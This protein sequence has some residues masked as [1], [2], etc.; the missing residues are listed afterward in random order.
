[1]PA[2]EQDRTPSSAEGRPFEIVYIEEQLEEGSKGPL[3]AIRRRVEKVGVLDFTS[4]G[5]NLEEFCNR[6]GGTLQAVGDAV[7]QYSLHSFELT[8]DVTA[9]G[10]VRFI[11]SAGTEIKGGLKL[12]FQRSK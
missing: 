12:V 11:G 3:G 1:M 10:E 5:V 8:V 2:G 6:I 4:F 7:S 9:K